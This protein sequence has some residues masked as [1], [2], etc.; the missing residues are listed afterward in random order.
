MSTQKP[1]KVNRLRNNEK[2]LGFSLLE[3][4]SI[5]HFGG[6]YLNKSH[7][8]VARPLSIKRSMHLV[9]RSSKAT[10]SYSFLKN[11]R[12]IFDIIYKQSKLHGVKIYRYA[13]AGNHLHLVILPRSASAYRKFI[14]AA[15][16][17]IARLI[18]HKERGAAHQASTAKTKFWDQRPY[19]RIVEWGRD[20]KSVRN[21]LMQNILEA[22]G[23][24]IYKPRK[25]Y[26]LSNKRLTTH[27]RST[28]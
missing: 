17:L 18:L 22:T 25:K 24:V 4:K 1:T 9:M 12:K 6:V 11:S 2:Q 20:F 7:P 28:A 19:T 21:Y 15:S 13:N 14:R 3:D 23:F 27:V 26:Q 8:K 10:G 5:K 16:G